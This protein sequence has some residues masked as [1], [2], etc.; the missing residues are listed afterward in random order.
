MNTM[1][2]SIRKSTDARSLVLTTLA[3]ACLAVA[4][5]VVHAADKS[6]DSEPMKRTVKY[7]DLNLANQQGVEQLYRRISGAAQ[8]VCDNGESRSLQAQAQVWICT[9]QTIARAVAAVNQ[10]ALTALHAIKTG[11]PESTAKLAKQ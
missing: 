1:N 8:H 5:T 2:T 9:Q 6:P 3:M 7:G 10:P 11:Q 4:S